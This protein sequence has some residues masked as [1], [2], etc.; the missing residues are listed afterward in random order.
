MSSRKYITNRR[1]ETAVVKN[2][3]KK[4]RIPFKSVGHGTGTAWG[5][6]EINLGKGNGR[7]DAA[8]VKVVQSVTGRHG[9]YDGN[10]LI[11]NQ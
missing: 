6:I 4:A 8:A 11:L 3:L 9:D 5:W 2:A 1:E 10:I 7:Y